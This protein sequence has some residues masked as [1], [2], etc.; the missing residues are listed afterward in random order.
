MVT[1]GNRA[2]VRGRLE[3][4]WGVQHR[5]LNYS[6]EDFNDEATVQQW[7][8]LGFTQR[9]F[10]GDMY[11]M[12]RSEPTFIAPF[13][14][15][16]PMRHFS[17]S[18]YRMPPGSVLPVHHD[19]YQRFREIHKL[20]HTAVIMRV[21]V[22]LEDWQSGHYLEMDDTPVLNW[23]AGEWVCWGNDFPHLAANIGRTDRYTLQITGI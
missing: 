5:D 17:W 15:H 4:W 18:F 21:I 8:K 23:R 11:D 3:P 20:D 7:R 10:T 12:R 6:N 22:F 9:R 1:P 2:W 14:E 19:T 16:F 13:R